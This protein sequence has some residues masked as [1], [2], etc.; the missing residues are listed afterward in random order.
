LV[1][2]S[3]ALLAS[4]AA[5]AAIGG[6]GPVVL[7]PSIVLRAPLPS[8]VRIGERLT[9]AGRVRIPPRAAQV[10]LQSTRTTRWRR[11]TSA[12]LHPRAA[13][14][15]RWRVPRDTTIGPLKLRLAVMRKGRL[16]AATSPAQSFVGS[17]AV[18]CKPAVPPAVDIPPGDGW[19]VGGV[20]IQGG[21]FPGVYECAGSPYTVTATNASDTVVASQTVA[22]LHSYTLVVPEGSYMLASGQCRGLA[23]V[24]AGRQTEADTNCDFP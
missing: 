5:V 3:A 2:G 8:V 14:N 15:L 22:A 9:V 12:S 13:F 17:A 18:Y 4:G 20:I 7:R 16:L 1:A 23:T 24:T 21:A 6:P 10:E 11:V 19:I